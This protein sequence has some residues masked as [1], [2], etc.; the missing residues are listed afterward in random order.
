MVKIKLSAVRMAAFTLFFL[1]VMVF[2]Q[3]HLELRSNL[4]NV[5]K[6]RSFDYDSLEQR[7][8][9]YEVLW[10]ENGQLIKHQGFSHED[11]LYEEWYTYELSGSKERIVRKGRS[12]NRNIV[13][14][15][16]YD[17]YGRLKRSSYYKPNASKPFYKQSKFRYDETGKLLSYR[18]ISIHRDDR[19]S[20]NLRL[21]Y[22]D[23]YSVRK[24]TLRENII[25]K[26]FEILTE[27]DPGFN[28]ALM[29][30]IT[31]EKATRERDNERV[32]G[33][34]EGKPPVTGWV[35][36]DTIYHND[37]PVVI[38]KM[39]Q[40]LRYVYDERGNWIEFY[41]VEENGMERLIESRIIE[42]KD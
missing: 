13:I 17:K 18:V 37:V 10:Y 11:L 27:Y 2:G 30:T 28:S 23:Q 39:I 3:H 33:M 9:D 15:N 16:Y 22:S 8:G 40:Q 4:E 21:T 32:R 25:G 14:I 7:T 19:S 24:E 35:E 31:Y 34:F 12:E 26:D 29:T 20:K 38:N 1:P 42:Y 41:K 6:I 36:K 5:A